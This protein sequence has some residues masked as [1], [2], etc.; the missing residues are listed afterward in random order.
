MKHLYYSAGQTVAH[1]AATGCNMSAG[2]MLGSGTI[3]APERSGFGS[4]VELCW[5]GKTNSFEIDLEEGSKIERK[6]LKDGDEINFTAVC[7]GNGY[8]IGFGDCSGKIL[9]AVDNSMFYDE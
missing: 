6:F 3:S 4:L 7:R 1:H 8:V 2:D 5:A 9:P